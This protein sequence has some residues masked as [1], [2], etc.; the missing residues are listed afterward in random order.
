M[1][2]PR[3]PW[4]W[5]GGITKIRKS[6]YM[7]SKMI[8][9]PLWK[10]SCH[11]FNQKYKKIEWYRIC[12]SVSNTRDGNWTENRHMWMNGLHLLDDEFNVM[13][14]FSY[15]SESNKSEFPVWSWNWKAKGKSL[16]LRLRAWY[17]W[18]WQIAV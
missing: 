8:G 6:E 18:E 7:L 14:Y 12:L 17:F 15:W 5:T 4:K 2:F 9:D 16:W 3:N 1:I 11:P 10:L 13:F